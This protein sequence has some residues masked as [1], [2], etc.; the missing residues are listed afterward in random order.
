VAAV[1]YHQPPAVLVTL[2]DM[3]GDVVID[4]GLQSLGEHPPRALTNELVDQRRA[5]I[6]AGVIGVDSSRNY[7]EHG[8]YPSDRRWRADLA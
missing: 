2:A 1:A 6:P 5:A 8:S 7:G 4:L 3:A